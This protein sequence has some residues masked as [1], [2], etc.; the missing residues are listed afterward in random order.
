[1]KEEPRILV[2]EDDSHYLEFL[3]RTLEHDYR[4]DVAEDG[5]QVLARLD[6]CNYDAILC[7]LRIPGLSGKE[8][9]HTIRERADRETLL[10][11]IT[12]FEQDWSPVDATEAHIYFYLKKGEFSPRDLRKVLKNGMDLR[13]ERLEKRQYARQL[14]QLNEGLERTVEER[15]HALRESEAKYRNLFQQSL[16]GIYTQLG[17]KI[18]FVNDR[19]CEMLDRRPEELAG[20]KM[21]DFLVPIPHDDAVGSDSV[22]T[23]VFQMQ[24]KFLDTQRWNAT[25]ANET[26]T[27]YEGYFYLNDGLYETSAYAYDSAGRLIDIASRQY[28]IY[29][30]W[31]FIL[32]KQ[33]LG[34]GTT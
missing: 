24:N 11:V 12:G 33:L 31:K 27:G 2:V 9:V 8:L 13:R 15:T 30:E 25:S 7:D 5:D 17:G 20:K 1:M 22:R 4:V 34:L 19:L 29:Y 32:L 28:V 26:G 16:V 3:T 10:I 18:L 21:E 6:Q 23:V 14:E